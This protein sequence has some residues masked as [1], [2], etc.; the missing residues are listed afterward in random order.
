LGDPQPG[1][2]EQFSLGSLEDGVHLRASSSNLEIGISPCQTAER[3]L[4]TKEVGQGDVGAVRIVVPCNVAR[5]KK[6]GPVDYR[7]AYTQQ[8]FGWL[9]S[10]HRLLG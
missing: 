5:V 6:V 10:V 7:C 4:L 1:F 9:N 3:T 8:Q 2:C